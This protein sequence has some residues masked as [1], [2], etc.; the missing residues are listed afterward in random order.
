[1]GLL[2]L[3]LTNNLWQVIPVLIIQQ[4]FFMAVMT[5][6]N[7]VLQSITPD[8]MRGRVMGLYMIDIG[9]QPLGGV[10]AGV[11]ATFYSV[12][13]AWVT[14]A[15]IGLIAV[16]LVTIFAPSFRRLQI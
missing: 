16:A 4:M 1:M 6:N 5:T 12:S 9:M 15:V 8:S 3:S 13:I 14:G 10:L 2:V 7:T 11:I